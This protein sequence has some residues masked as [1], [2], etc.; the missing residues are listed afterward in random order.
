MFFH[1]NPSADRSLVVLHKCDNPRCVN[2]DHLQLGTQKDNM[3]DMLRK[4][5]H[6][7]GAPLGNQNAKGNKGW[8]KG[9]IT[10]RYVASKLGDEVEVPDELE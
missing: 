8:M 1:V 2:P 4:G 7:G 9:G 3:L 5:R 6:R 10:A